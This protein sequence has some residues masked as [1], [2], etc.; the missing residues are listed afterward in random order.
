MKKPPDER[1]LNT[2]AKRKK[3]IELPIA[4]YTQTMPDD[5]SDFLQDL[6][7]RIRTER[8]KSVLS[9]NAALVM[10]YWDIGRAILEKQK[11]EGW[12]A[13]IID[14]MAYDL[15]EEF[16]DMCGFSARNLKDMRKFAECWTDRE[17]VQRTAAQIP[18]RNNQLLLYKLKESDIRIWYAEQ[19]RLNGWSRDI[20][21]FQIESCLHKRIGQTANN[22]E[23]AF[24]PADS[25]MV[26][27]IFKDPYVF[28][29]LGTADTRRERELENKLME[30]LEK[31]LLELGQ[32]FAFVGR[33][34]HLEFSDED[35]YIDLLF[36]H[37]KLRC[38]VVV[39]LKSGKFDPGY[40]GKL[41]MY[42]NIVND[43]L[44]HSDDQKTIGLLLVK[45][46]NHTIAKYALEGYTNPIGVA[47]WEKQITENLP[48]E[49]MS[50]LPTIEEIEAELE[51]G[52]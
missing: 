5:Y 32:G 34:V 52:E 9:A 49:L 43:L 10:L 29:F 31:F 51:G 38:Y 35:Y 40:V 22:F 41:N 3:G 33:Q 46:K 20:L 2:L 30:H 42:M 26:N 25:D 48:E 37:L 7:V 21:S 6:K 8:S 45:E 13:K 1:K 39:E 11:D 15:K 24:P 12:G 23:V 4:D 47:E 14:R 27:H 44:R 17:I 36:Y 28:D 16:P 19:N 18:W 50:S